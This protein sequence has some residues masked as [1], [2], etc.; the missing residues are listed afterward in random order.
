MQTL[1]ENAAQVTVDFLRDALG[2]SAVS[3]FTSKRIGTGLVG[4]CH[5]IT[6]SYT[7]NDD[8][9]PQTV[10]LKIASQD[11]RSRASGL[12]LGIYENEVR[13]YTEVAPQL[14]S[15]VSSIAKC[16]YG[17]FDNSTGIFTLLLEDAGA[18][19][20][21]GDDI[22]AATREQADAA[23]YELGRLHA[24]LI[25]D[26]SNKEWL[27]RE[28]PI[29]PP[30]LR[31]LFA[32][33]STRYKAQ[34]DTRHYE[35]CQKLVAGFRGLVELLREPGTC[36]MAITHGDYR[37]DN[38]LYKPDGRV[39]VVDWQC[40]TA[41][42]VLG[43]V[44][45]FLGCALKTQD[46]REWQ[47]ELLAIY[48]KGLEDVAGEAVLTVDDC[49]RELQL[50]AFFGV[51]M[52]IVS[53]IQAG[54]TDRGDEMFMTMLARHCELVGDLD[55]MAILPDSDDE[56]MTP[57]RPTAEDEQQ[58]EPG[59]EKDWNESWYFDFVGKEQGVAG[60]VRL[61]LVPNREGNWYQATVTR[62][63]E[64]TV[65]VSD[66]MAPRPDKLHVKTA[67]IE[68]THELLEPLKK[69][70]LTLRASGHHHAQKPFFDASE[71]ETTLGLDLRFDT[72]GVPYRY[73]ITTRYEIPCLVSGTITLQDSTISLDRVPGQRD[74]SF[75]V[76]D[77]WSMDWV[78][79]SFHMENGLHYHAT[80][81]RLPD[82]PR[83]GM[84][85]SQRDATATEIEQLECDE[86][87]DT[88]GLVTAMTM[89]I[90]L[91]G[92]DEQTLA[93]VTPVRHTA[94]KLPSPD[95]RVALFDRAWAEVETQ[96]GEKGVGWFEWN[97]NPV[98]T[99]R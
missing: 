71:A 55:A 51:I 26:A 92:S 17:A 5:R 20:T 46:R 60:W 79:A 21:P 27:V 12:S 39:M 69:F 16:Y 1:I 59:P 7:N 72:A 63:G 29:S 49:M 31:Q 97:H 84:G 62:E 41:G 76:R 32:S 24:A 53:S 94:L 67:K 99:P 10:I 70:R 90:K 85:Y 95:T 45:Y 86:I 15:M 98:V 18:D 52:A 9:L 11:P 61:G 37:L 35:I 42:P 96:D 8:S 81:L 73:R 36:T 44:A 88:S 14:T 83:I 74:H 50:N 40:V 80:D 6:L 19:A 47:Q 66:F 64:P 38:M 89:T 54:R 3:S 23:M 22:A 57:L 75:G 4:E 13:F 48:C 56:D 65:M 77:W 30:L 82:V 33:F 43:D 87:K 78:W 25:M 28:P 93:K 68:A 91:L 2:S 34:M 58:H